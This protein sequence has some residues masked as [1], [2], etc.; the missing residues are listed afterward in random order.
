MSCADVTETAF[1]G[2][3]I[4]LVCQALDKTERWDLGLAEAPHVSWET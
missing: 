4:Y 3:W 2:V 1:L